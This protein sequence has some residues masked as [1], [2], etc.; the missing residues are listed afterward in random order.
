MYEY[1]AVAAAIE[2]GDYSLAGDLFA[3]D[4]TYQYGAPLSITEFERLEF[5]W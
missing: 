3:A 2:N 4:L 5:N 1:G